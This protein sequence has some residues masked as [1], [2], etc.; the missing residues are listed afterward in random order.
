MT[1]IV[2]LGETSHDLP[3]LINFIK[4][5]DID[6]IHVYGLI[7]HKG[8]S[9]AETP[10]P[11]E[12]EQA[13]WIANLRIAFPSLDIQC[14]IWEDR[15]ERTSLLLKAGANS[16]SKYKALHLFGKEISYQL[17]EQIRIAGRTM[18]GTLTVT[19]KIAWD[20]EIDELVKYIRSLQKK[21][22]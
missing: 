8:T 13:W 15:I 5:Y 19:P 4:T 7:P 17:E 3:L 18:L 10:P 12:E 22:R 11:T 2:G 20:K 14:G 1:F 6:K 9:C 21:G 16:V